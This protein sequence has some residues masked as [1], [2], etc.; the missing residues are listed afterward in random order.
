MQEIVKGGNV[1]L[2]DFPS[3]FDSLSPKGQVSLSI[4][5]HLNCYPRS[6]FF[7]CRIYIRPYSYDTGYATQ[8][9][10]LCLR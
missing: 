7:V 9:I 4:Y 1:N 2:E 5:K 3:D 8:R 6:I 10:N